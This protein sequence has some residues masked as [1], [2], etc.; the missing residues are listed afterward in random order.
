MIGNKRKL[1]E[2]M[3]YHQRLIDFYS[4]DVNSAPDGK[5]YHQLNHGK[6]QFILCTA[7]DGGRRRISVTNNEEILRAMTQSMPGAVSISW[8]TTTR[9]E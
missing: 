8:R 6:D 3:T 7:G 9:Q 1:E 2:I 4:R 5:L